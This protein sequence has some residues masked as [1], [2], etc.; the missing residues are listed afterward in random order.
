MFERLTP[1][2]SVEF[3]A[4]LGLPFTVV[5]TIDE[6][7]SCFAVAD[8]LLSMMFSLRNLSAFVSLETE[9]LGRLF[10]V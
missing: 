3:D 2:S 10:S 1:G 9:P 7:S 8:L 5:F 6:S 4:G